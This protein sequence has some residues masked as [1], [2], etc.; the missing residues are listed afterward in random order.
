MNTDKDREAEFNKWDGCDNGASKGLLDCQRD[1]V[2]FCPN[3]RCETESI[4]R[5]FN[6]LDSA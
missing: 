1:L 2:N 6:C 3:H 5:L 4:R